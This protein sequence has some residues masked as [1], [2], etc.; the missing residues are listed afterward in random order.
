MTLTEDIPG[1]AKRKGELLLNGL[2]PL[3]ERYPEVLK[4]ARGKG[5]LIG[6]EFA[7]DEIGYSVAKELFRHRIL[8]SGT[9]NNAR[10][11]RLEPPAIITEDEIATVLEALDEALRTVRDGLVARA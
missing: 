1:Q 11:V 3:V 5:L 4:D 10:V 7:N 8:V 2:R 9:L 6:L